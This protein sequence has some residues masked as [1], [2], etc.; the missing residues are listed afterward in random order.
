MIIVKELN[1]FGHYNIM[2]YLKNSITLFLAISL[3]AL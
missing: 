1:T 2:N 3:N